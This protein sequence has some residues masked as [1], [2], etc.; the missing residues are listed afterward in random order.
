MA[1]VAGT[2]QDSIGAKIGVSGGVV[3][4]AVVLVIAVYASSENDKQKARDK[5]AR[6]AA[7]RSAAVT[8]AGVLP[9]ARQVAA[10]TQLCATGRHDLCPGRVQA[11]QTV[12]GACTCTCHTPAMSSFCG[13]HARHDLCPGVFA[14]ALVGDAP[15]GCT[16][17]RTET[18]WKPSIE[19]PR[20]SLGQ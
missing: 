8:G 4:I 14:F 3:V 12:V 16:C 6:D 9:S 13:D 19:P 1:L 20:R 5:Q 11:S 15:C 17:H 18:T 10:Q 7:Q 2:I